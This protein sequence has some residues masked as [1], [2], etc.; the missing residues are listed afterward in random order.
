MKG[1]FRALIVS[2]VAVPAV[3]AAQQSTRPQ[4]SAFSYSYAELEYADT[5]YDLGQDVDGDGFAIKGSY[6]LNDDWHVFA[7]YGMA[8]LDFGL[9]LDTLTVG[10]GYVYPLRDDVDI[11][12]RVMYVKQDFDP[13]IN[14]DD[15]GLGLQARIRTRLSDDFEVE[16]GIQYMHVNDSDTS[17]QAEGRY[18]F[19]DDFS[20]G[21]GLSFAGDADG[22]GVSIR[23][24]F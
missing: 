14:I 9:D 16:G 15:D 22:I 18:Y 11:Y 7:S 17:L 20:V 2:A 24:S 19:N 6:E 5:E 21:V 13:S 12:G 8:D 23:Y 10:A 1:V 4:S 3:C